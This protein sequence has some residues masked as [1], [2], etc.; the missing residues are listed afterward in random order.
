MGYCVSSSG[1]AAHGPGRVKT[2]GS[3]GSASGET[4]GR[5]AATVGRYGS[6]DPKG[7][8]RSE[9]EMRTSFAAADVHFR[10]S[11]RSGEDPG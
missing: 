5:C 3:D 4:D 10:T 9:I 7:D 2:V 6:V 8:V 1:D 11:N